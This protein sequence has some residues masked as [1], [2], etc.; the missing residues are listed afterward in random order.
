MYSARMLVKPGGTIILAAPCLEGF[1]DEP[2]FLELLKLS[3]R[4]IISLVDTGAEEDLFIATPAAYVVQVREECDVIMVS[5]GISREE[6]R[7]IKFRYAAD[8]QEA[9]ELALLRRGPE[10]KVAVMR[11]GADLIPAIPGEE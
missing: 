2:R 6:S 4:E 3:R 9:L 8:I 10:A 5:E 1:G 7:M 11:F